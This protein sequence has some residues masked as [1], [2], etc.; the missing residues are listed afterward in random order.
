MSEWRAALEEVSATVTSDNV[1]LCT[2]TTDPELAQ[3]WFTRFEGAGLDG[4][5]AKPLDAP[6]SPDKRTVLKGLLHG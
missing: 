3:E 4:V 2:T 6:Y 1:H 5:M